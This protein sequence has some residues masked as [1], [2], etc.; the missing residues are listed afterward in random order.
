[1]KF[2][3][4]GFPYTSKMDI[5]KNYNVHGFLNRLPEKFKN[6]AKHFPETSS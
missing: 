1:M 4:T 6:K 3:R 2:V 5:K